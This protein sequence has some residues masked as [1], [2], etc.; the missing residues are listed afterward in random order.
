MF[1]MPYETYTGTKKIEVD[2]NDDDDDN[3]NDNND[4]DNQDDDNQHSCS[5][6]STFRKF[7][8]DNIILFGMTVTFFSKTCLLSFILL[9]GTRVPQII[10]KRRKINCVASIK[11]I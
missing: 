9:Q 7:V 1:I 2:D 11:L 4:D 8:S 5:K 10:L 3:D 6:L